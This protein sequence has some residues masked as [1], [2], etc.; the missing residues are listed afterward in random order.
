MALVLLVA[1]SVDRGTDPG[2]DPVRERKPGIN[3]VAGAGVTD[4]IDSFVLP[5]LE[6][7]VLDTELKPIA[8]A[9][10]DFSST[11]APVTGQSYSTY[12][13][14][15]Q[16]V[17]APSKSAQASDTTDKD[18]RVSISVVLGQRPGSGGI[19]ISVPSRGWIDT[20]RYTVTVGAPALSNVGPKEQVL[21]VGGTLQVVGTVTDR[22][23]NLLSQQPRLGVTDA[24]ISIDGSSVVRTSVPT[25]SGVVAT[26]GTTKPDTAWVNVT[27]KGTFAAEVS[28]QLAVMELDGSDRRVIPNTSTTGEPEWMPDGSALLAQL[29]PSTYRT[30]HRVELDGRISPVYSLGSNGNIYAFAPTS[31]GALLLSGGG[32]NYMQILYVLP[33]DST[34]LQ[35]LSPPAADDCF[36]TVDA[37]PS[38]APDGTRVVLEH[39]TSY[40]LG[41][42]VRLLDI[43]TRAITP[44]HPTG[45]RPRWS[46]RGDLIAFT[47]A[48]AISVIKPDGG[49]LRRVSPPTRTYLPGV[50]WSPDGK[51][52]LAQIAP[53]PRSSVPIAVLEVETGMEILLPYTIPAYQ[54]LFSTPVW[55]PNP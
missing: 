15:V 20:A 55:R 22:Y 41:S 47:D 37:F 50:S 42:S 11:I 43:A 9:R 30:I 12:M 33:R 29:R 36:D 35:R 23:G 2:S 48:G 27:P 34:R 10:V 32:C 39:R 25:R 14:F 4:T 8:N 38:P 46:P 28:G 26:F 13:A 24:R 53:S 18:G 40:F 3:I 54:N 45:Q 6:V 16:R 19:A 7:L 31:D 5:P 52:L 21:T 51:Y 1:C 17:D 49:G 44:L